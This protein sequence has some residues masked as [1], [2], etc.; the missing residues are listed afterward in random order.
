M[1]LSLQPLA[2]M[3]DNAEM[4]IVLPQRENYLNASRFELNPEVRKPLF[5]HIHHTSVII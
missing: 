2:D 4:A 1:L 3:N 5:T